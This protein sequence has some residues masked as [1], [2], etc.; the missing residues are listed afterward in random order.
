[1]SSK[2]DNQ[3][4]VE[5][6]Q[7]HSFDSHN[8]R[9]H[10]GCESLLAQKGICCLYKAICETK[11][12]KVK[13]L[14]SQWRIMFGEIC[15]FD[16]D[17]DNR[18]I[19]KLGL[20]FGIPS[21]RSPELL[22]AIHT[23]Y[24]IFI[25]FLAAKIAGT[26]GAVAVS[27]IKKGIRAST[28]EK[29]MI[30]TESLEQDGIWSKLGINNFLEGDLFSWHLFAWNDDLASFIRDL[31]KKLDE[32]DLTTL[33]V[34]SAESHDLLKKLYE[35]LFPPDISKSIGEYYTP[36][37]LAEYVLNKLGYDGDP[38]KR[39]LDPSCGSGTFIVVAINRIKEWFEKHRNECGFDES[40]LIKK[41]ISNIIG[42]DLNPLAV[43]TARTNYLI[44][45]RDLLKFAE[46]FEIPIYLCDSIMPPI[47]NGNI[48]KLN[49][50]AGEFLI[51]SEIATS[52]KQIVKYFQILEY[53]IENLYS[54][55]DFIA[56]CKNESLPISEIKLHRNL[57]GQLLLL[58]KEGKN[59]FWARFIKNAFAPIFIEP[60]D[61]VVGNP[62]W[63]SWDSLSP[64]YRNAVARVWKSE[65]LHTRGGWLA[66]VGGGKIDL[67]ALFVYISFDRFI[68]KHG[69]LGF[70]LTQ[71]LFKTH[72]GGE[73]FRRF[74]CQSGR[75]FAPLTVEDL[76]NVKVFPKASNRS[77]VAIFQSGVLPAYPL[78][79]LKWQPKGKRSVDP[80]LRLE[81]VL[82]QF[83]LIPLVAVPIHLEDPCSP[84]LTVPEEVVKTARKLVGKSAY[85]ARGGVN[86]GGMNAVYWID[87]VGKESK[88]YVEIR[89]NATSARK[90][91]EQIIKKVESDLVYPLLRGRDILRW[92][93]KPSKHI[94]L[95]YTPETAK[96]AIPET[97]LKRNYPQTFSFFQ[98]FK[99]FLSGRSEYA[100]WG[101]KGPFYEIY[102]IGD[103]TF[104]LCKVVWPHVLSDK[105]RASVVRTEDEK[106]PIPDQKV[107]MVAFDEEDEAHYFC[108]LLNSSS[109]FFLLRGYLVLDASP[110]VLDHIRIPRWDKSNPIHL[111]LAELSRR[112][113]FLTAVG[114]DTSNI[115]AKIDQIAAQ[116][117]GISK[118][119]LNNLQEALTSLTTH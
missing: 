94:I 97:V 3:V 90:K 20:H 61:Y 42:F 105:M 103:Y 77:A 63:V 26:F 75:Y 55:G 69:K 89:N 82:D 74:K 86:T 98:S 25:K 21:P 111:K 64:D 13:T 31:V 59:S 56:K 66:K 93:A 23:Y 48:K 119:E 37:W 17:R 35:G 100:R 15:G 47:E 51:P 18:N 84:W 112:A 33:S 49:T 80:D 62:P 14:F 32:F 76:S 58:N 104:S 72:K 106:V 81:E 117:W 4:L 101:G 24:A 78:K 79:Y 70:V 43:M 52:Y 22:F 114:K 95:P 73:G 30:E 50:S 99:R 29:L 60:V 2:N 57:Y 46:P 44:A 39:L 67:A 116:L 91:V 71:T 107:I 27:P 68:K 12:V 108:A 11:E 88:D 1:M 85:R 110:H 7:G 118:T 40:S 115:E 28:S 8:L 38:D 45:I 16:L 10:F 65:G 54:T 9:K 5:Q 92:H 102:R 87:I 41:I 113:H 109:A 53:C 34:D 6:A 96:K 19:N 36:D 83:E